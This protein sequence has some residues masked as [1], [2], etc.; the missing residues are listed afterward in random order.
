MRFLAKMC[1][2]WLQL[3]RVKNPKG[4]VFYLQVNATLQRPDG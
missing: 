1:L 2:E 4:F 3:H